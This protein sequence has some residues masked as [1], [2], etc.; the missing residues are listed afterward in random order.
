MLGPGRYY[1]FTAEAAKTFGPKTE[2]I[3]FAPENPL[4]IRSDEEWRALTREAG[5]EFPNPFGLDEA[6]VSEMTRRLQEVVRGRGHDAV[7]P[8]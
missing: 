2:Q 4:V 3:E 5:W 7:V 8:G 1:A 6:E